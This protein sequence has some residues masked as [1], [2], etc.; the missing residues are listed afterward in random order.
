VQEMRQR[1]AEPVQFPDDQAI[2]GP[3]VVE[4]LLES[5]AIIPRTA[6]LI[7]K[8]MTR[9][10]AGG[11]Q[12]VALQGRRLPVGVT[13]DPHV[14][15]EHVRKT[16]LSSFP[17]IRAIR[18]GLSDRF[19]PGLTGASRPRGPVSGNTCLADRSA[20]AI[21][22]DQKVSGRDEQDLQAAARWHVG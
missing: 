7:F 12:C 17:S 18:Q 1:A 16:P 2:A 19:C 6:G 11:E 5:S 13:G 10:D 14:P 4:R 22:N 8:Q 20:E 3:D 9:I 21:R 15:H